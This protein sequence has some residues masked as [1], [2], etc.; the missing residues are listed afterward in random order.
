M[1]ADGLHNFI[2]GI[3]IAAAFLTNPALGVA[4]TIAVA[5]HEIPQEIV[6]FSIL[7]HSGF[8]RARAL[9]LN[10]LSALV[11]IGGAAF[12]L[13]IGSRAELFT[14]AML[15]LTAGMFVYLAGSDLVP[16]LHKDVSVSQAVKQVLMMGL[17]ILILVALA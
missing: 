11:A 6:D 14:P 17:G 2:D 13:I 8:T 1:V 4:T 3:V 16:D 15:A 7:I 10:F 9:F 5:I 12:A